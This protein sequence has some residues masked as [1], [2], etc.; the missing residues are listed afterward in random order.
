MTKIIQLVDFHSAL[1]AQVRLHDHYYDDQENDTRLTGYMP[2]RAHREAFLKLAQSQLPDRSNK[3]KVF[4]LTGSFGTGKSHLCLMLANYFSRKVSAPEMNVLFER[5]GRR[6]APGMNQVR[7]M[8]GEGRYLVAICEFGENK[9]FEDMVLSAIEEALALE[10]AENLELDTHFKGV[11]RQ[12]AYWEERRDAGEPSGA[13]DDFLYFLGGDDGQD[14][15]DALKDSLAQNSTKAMERFQDAYRQATGQR[16]TMRTDNLMAVLEDLL[17]S[18]EF[19]QRYRG[20]VILADEFGYA[21]SEGRVPM[22][23]FQSFAE[24]SKDGVDGTPL[25]FVGTGHRRFEAYGANT[26]SNIDF[27]VVRDRVTEVSLASEELEQIIAALISPK[28]TDEWKEVKS[29]WLLGRMAS[30]A[31]KSDARRVKLFEYLPEPD[32][33]EQIVRNIYPMHPLAVYCLTH[34]SQELGSDARSVFSFF[35]KAEFPAPGS[36]QWFTAENEIKK[37][38][39]ELNIYTPDLL[40]GYFAP[41]VQSSNMSV[42]PEIHD[43]IRNY[44][45]ALEEA[46][47]LARNTFTGEVDP[48]TQSVLDLIFVYRVSGIPVTLQ[49]LAYGLNYYRPEQQKRLGGELKTLG[50]AKVIFQGVSGEFEFRRSNMADVDTLV[51]QARADVAARPLDLADKMSRLA[52]RFWDSWTVA[53]GHNASYHGDK[54]LRRVFATPQD[55]LRKT[56]LPDGSE[57]TFWSRLER[58]RSAPKSWSDRYDGVMVYVLC[59]N[60]EDI[61]NAQQAAKSNPV[62]ATIVGIP[63]APIPV[64]EKIIDLLAVQ[65]FMNTLEFNKLDAQEKSLVEEMLGKEVQKKGRVGEVIKLRERYLQAKDLTWYQ[66]DG[67][68]LLAEPNSEHDPADALMSALFKERNFAEHTILNLAHPKTF[69]GTRDS[70]LRDAVA[71]LVAFDKPVEIDG[72]EKESMG[73]IRYLRNALV[74]NGVLRQT[75]DY[76]GSSAFYELDPNLDSYANKFPALVHLVKLLKNISRGEKLAFWPRLQELTEAPYG[77]GPFALCLFTAV[78]VRYLGDEM[79]LKLNPAGLGYA[80]VTEPDI[81]I[82]LA[83]GKYAN[84]LVERRERTPAMIELIDGIYNIFSETPS[85]AGTHCSQIETWLVLLSWWK[86]RTKLERTSGIYADDSEAQKLA[87][88]LASYENQPAASQAIIDEIKGVYGYSSDADLDDAQVKELLEKLQQERQVIETRAK[89]IKDNL[90]TTLGKLFNPEA[91]TYMDYT[92]AVRD[93]VNKLHP[94]QLDRNASWQQAQSATLVDALPKMVDIQKMLLEDIPAAPG[95][96]YGKVDDWGYNRSQEYISRFQ[97]AIHIIENGL[98]KV[99]PPTWSTPAESLTNTLGEAQ[100]QFHGQVKLTVSAPEGVTVRVAVNEDV[101]KAK[102]FE[103]VGGGQSESF[104][105]SN[106]CYYTLVSLN[107]HGDLSK[108]VKVNF[109]NLDDEYKLYPETQGKLEAVDR[110]YRFRNPVHGHNLTV[111][112]RHLIR[113][114]KADGFISL[115]N[116]REAFEDALEA[117][118]GDKDES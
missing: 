86:N 49:N 31:K 33:L 88:L 12:I 81:V 115:E 62:A 11:L 111:L 72:N 8:R 21:L 29:N 17:A 67:K 117:E 93:W 104:E 10:G 73:E 22:S 78:A 106:T 63:Q 45:A 61:L 112:L 27:R 25:I 26:P 64:K 35:R 77:L 116:I 109:R 107:P 80:Q 59:E 97:S 5:W 105:V 15:L 69:P 79:R 98:P 7:N 4:M 102:Q 53:S 39:G 56:A 70:A 16:F 89:S 99:A 114:L 52:E 36:Y 37:P 13:F 101:K 71:R 87:G 42:R 47:K 65:E 32:L 19:K 51:N 38:D 14:E 40:V 60:Q 66:K 84:A 110:F 118:L 85:A 30:E 96:G 34:M 54:R 68:V 91:K 83:T 75:G 90:V 1:G 46:Q 28:D 43:Y 44:L 48:F 76:E 57:L 94:D 74:N 108:V 113:H 55:L 100:V 9:P 23:V 103:A 2:I 82:D 50:E 41:E 6:D 3:D 20:L 95:F 58:E 24:M 92:D 18:P